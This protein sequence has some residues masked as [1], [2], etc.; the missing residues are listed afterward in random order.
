MF[1]NANEIPLPN[2]RKLRLARREARVAQRVRLLPRQDPAVAGHGADDDCACGLQEAPQC[3]LVW[4]PREVDVDAVD[5]AE[6][7]EDHVDGY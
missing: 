5:C 7:G 6:D 1:P 3:V 4:E 2:I